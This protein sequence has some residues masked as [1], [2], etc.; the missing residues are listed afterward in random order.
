MSRAI[1]TVIKRRIGVVALA[2]SAVTGTAAKAEP[3]ELQL[4]DQKAYDVR[5]AMSCLAYFSQKIRTDTPKQSNVDQ[6][7]LDLVARELRD[8]LEPEDAKRPH[9]ADYD[10][11]PPALTANE[12]SSGI[13]LYFRFVALH[14]ISE[15]EER[16]CEHLVLPST[17]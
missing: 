14:P 16:R 9:V 10:N 17:H 3:P 6:Y 8:L 15:D 11:M 1:L 4:P 5:D 7:Y 12:I 13:L 2:L